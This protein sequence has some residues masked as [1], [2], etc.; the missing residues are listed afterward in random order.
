MGRHLESEP[1]TEDCFVATP[2]W[3]DTESRVPLVVE[4]KLA[5]IL[6]TGEDDEGDSG[7]GDGILAEEEV[8]LER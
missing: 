6:V 3:G 1:G 8:L 2:S 4:G 5:A 7:I